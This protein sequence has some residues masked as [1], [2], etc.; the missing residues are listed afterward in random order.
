MVKKYYDSCDDLPMSIFIKVTETGD[1]LLLSKTENVS[2]NKVVEAWSK[3]KEEFFEKY[4]DK[5]Y[6]DRYYRLLAKYYH[7]IITTTLNNNDIKSTV[8]L[9]KVERELEAMT[10]EGNDVDYYKVKIWIEQILGFYLDFEKVTVR[11]F[12]VYVET[13]RQIVENRNNNNNNNLIT[14]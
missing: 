10:K 8:E 12:F 3:I 13:A 7:L 6:S 2:Y 1:V 5:S 4:A 11:E 9:K 14:K